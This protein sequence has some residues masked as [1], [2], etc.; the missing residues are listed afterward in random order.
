MQTKISEL[1]EEL[2]LLAEERTIQY[3][4]KLTNKNIKLPP[5]YD[6][7]ILAIAFEW[8]KTPEKFSFWDL[9]DQKK[10]EEVMVLKQKEE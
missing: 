2:R 7:D 1:P 5:N 9:V 4:D 8:K 6:S 3:I 10:Y